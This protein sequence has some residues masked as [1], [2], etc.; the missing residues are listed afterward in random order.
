M[1]PRRILLFRRWVPFT[2]YSGGMLAK[3]SGAIHN[4]HVAFNMSAQEYQTFTLPVSVIVTNHPKTHDQTR[5][6]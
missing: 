2:I 1:A 5:F 3:A 4:H 6:L